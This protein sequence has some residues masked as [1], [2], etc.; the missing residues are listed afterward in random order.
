LVVI[1]VF[2]GTLHLHTADAVHDLGTGQ[3]LVLD[4]DIEHDV[5]ALEVSDTL[6]AVHLDQ[7]VVHLNR[8]K[9]G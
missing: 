8:A 2:T 3:V 5:E 9:M 4:R 7:V 1:Q 6:L